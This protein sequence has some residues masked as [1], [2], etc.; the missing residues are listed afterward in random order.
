MNNLTDKDFLA[1]RVL[2]P[3]ELTAESGAKDKY[4]G[5]FYE[6]V[7]QECPYCQGSGFINDEEVCEECE[8]AGSYGLKVCISW[9]T[10]K[11]FY[12]RVVSDYGVEARS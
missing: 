10:I 11:E 9:T 1:K 7:L 4:I 2:M 6:D 3:R 12:K 5:K 8:G